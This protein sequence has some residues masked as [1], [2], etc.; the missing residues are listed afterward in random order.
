MMQLRARDWKGGAVAIEYALVL[1]ALLAFLFAL[2]D[3][4]RLI[5]TQTTLD[6]A[7]QAAARCAVIDSV[8]CGSAGQVKAFAIA[9]AYGMRIDSGTISV[10]TRSC[11]MEVAATLAFQPV[12][13]WFGT[14]TI[15]LNARACYPAHPA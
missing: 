9:Q 2:I 12:V 14:S 1:P 13:P 4:G 7:M 10:A 6:H 11:G 5:W 3:T 8:Q 15:G